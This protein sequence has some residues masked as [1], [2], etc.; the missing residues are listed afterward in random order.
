MKLK[1]KKINEIIKLS[2]EKIPR[3]NM[4]HNFYYYENINKFNILYCYIKIT[5]S[6]HLEKTLD[7]YIF[8]NIYSSKSD[9]S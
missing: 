1:I 4:K 3:K 2:I 7:F 9:K 6:R 8:C 5:I